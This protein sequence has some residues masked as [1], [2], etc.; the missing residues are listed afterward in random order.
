MFIQV[1]GGRARLEDHH[2][3]REFKIVVD[4][5]IEDW[6]MLRTA[7]VGIARVDDGLPGWVLPSALR[8]DPLV[9]GDG[10]WQSGFDAMIDKARPHGW[11]DPQSGEIRAHI[12]WSGG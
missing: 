6:K 7:L 5:E 8:A 4:Q 10:V 3:F 1:S 11:V 2:N 12:V 9:A